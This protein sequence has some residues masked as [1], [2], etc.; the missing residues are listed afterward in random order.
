MP[1]IHQIWPSHLSQLAILTKRI[2][3]LASRKGC[4]QFG[5]PKDVS[6]ALSQE[7]MDSTVWLISAKAAARTMPMLLLVK[8]LSAKLTANL[9][10]SR[11]QQSGMPFQPDRSP[12][13]SLTWIQSP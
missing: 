9:A 13:L 4:A 5:T 6:W 10:I 12:E 8:C 11:T 3:P 7:Q 2:A 1:S